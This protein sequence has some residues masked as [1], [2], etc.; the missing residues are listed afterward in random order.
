MRTK[1]K[2]WAEPYILEHPEYRVFDEDISSLN[3]FY[4][5]IGSGKG[6]FLLEMAKKNPSFNFVGIER[7]VTCSGFIMKKLVENEV[8]N[9]KLIWGDASRLLAN[10]KDKTANKIF[11]N[12]SDPWPKERHTKRRL[13]SEFFLTNYFRILKDEGQIV[14][15]TD[16][17]ECLSITWNNLHHAMNAHFYGNNRQVN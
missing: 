2:A 3:D 1:F 4:L 5:E 17:L 6:L 8:S 15:K 14:F 16:N 13:T 12:F 9:A 10:F 7:N 11:L